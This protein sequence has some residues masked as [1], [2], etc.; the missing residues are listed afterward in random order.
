M[1]GPPTHK[2]PR[3][4]AGRLVLIGGF[5][6]LLLTVPSQGTAHARP[7]HNAAGTRWTATWAAS[8]TA[9][10]A[11]GL[12]AT[13]LSDQ[14][15]RDVVH[16]SVGGWMLRIRLTNRYGDRPVTF[17][18]MSVGIA[19]GAALVHGV[20]ITFGGR[21]A[22]TIPA[23][24]DVASDAVR[25]TVGPQEKV[26][27][28][29]HAPGPTG[30]ASWHS[31]AHTTSYVAVGDH[32]GDLSGDA[33]TTRVTSWYFLDGVDVLASP[34]DGTIVALGDSITD[35]TGTALDSDTR[36]TDDLAR[37][38]DGG[39]PGGRASVVNA[40]IGGNEVTLDRQPAYFG[41]SALHRLDADVLAQPGV[42][43]VIVFEGVNDLT[44]GAVPATRLIAGLRQVA[45]RVHAARLPVIGATITPCGGYP[46]CGAQVEEQ[47]RLVN[48][49]IRTSGVFDAVLDFDSVVRDPA[50]TDALQAGFD[51]GDHLHP[52]AAAYQA[53]ADTIDLRTLA[54]LS[55]AGPRDTGQHLT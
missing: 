6:A 8:P 26:A 39:P 9:A 16:T 14:T 52:N 27:V 4:H 48:A 23:G 13:G 21:P 5:G 40:G 49:W 37:R 55:G 7:A 41:V 32:A 53:M 24:A 19:D 10:A 12:S 36:W 18:D 11:T 38:I 22:V 51:S 45:D 34:R 15:V 35:G 43:A 31:A 46:V 54:H 3:G 2:S 20:R 28:S 44:A 42:S 30:P 1:A 17:D 50:K 47:R 25:L 29:L 33:F